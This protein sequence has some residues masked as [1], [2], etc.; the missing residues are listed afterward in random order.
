ML[1]HHIE[2]SITDILTVGKNQFKTVFEPEYEQIHALEGYDRIRKYYC[3]LGEYDTT[4][5]NVSGQD[6]DED[7]KK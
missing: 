4:D 6:D 2:I 1:S 7:D 5:N 3:Q